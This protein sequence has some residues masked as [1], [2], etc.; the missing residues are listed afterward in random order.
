MV[1]SRTSRPDRIAG[2]AVALFAAG[3]VVWES[4]MQSRWA[5]NAVTA[6]VLLCGAALAPLNLPLL[7]TELT[8]R[9]AAL[10]HATPQIERG[11]TSPLPQWLADR[12]GWEDFISQI[13]AVLA[14]LSAEDRSRALLFAPDYGH[15]GAM[16]LWGP[17]R[18][19]PPV[20]CT[21]NS[22]YHWSMG[23][24]DSEVLITVGV[25]ESRLREL[26]GEVN[27][28][29]TVTCSTCMSWRKGRAI[30]V[31][32]R[33]IVPLSSVWPELRHYE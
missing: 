6:A 14:T 23:H 4:G 26:F 13:D 16:E 9:Y 12:T 11:K 20:I 3:A 15:A 21:Q 10:L 29:G 32:R 18:G 28:V 2:F 24:T 33:P 30:H 1:V 17:A 19:F 31:S 8:G 7:P 5:R 22:Y 25:S 27:R